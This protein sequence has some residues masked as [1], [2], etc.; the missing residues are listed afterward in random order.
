VTRS[1]FQPTRPGDGSPNA[2]LPRLS[3]RLDAIGHRLA[4][5]GAV[6]VVMLDTA[7]LEGIEWDYGPAAYERVVGQLQALLHDVIAPHLHAGDCQVVTQP[8]SNE[9]VTFLFR[10]RAD[11]AFYQ[12][13]LPAIQAAIGRRIGARGAKIVHPYRPSATPL[14]VGHALA[15]HDATVSDAVQ[16][17]RVL[18]RA[19]RDADLAARIEQQRRWRELLHIVFTEQVSMHYQPIAFLGDLE[20]FGYEALVRGPDG[21]EFHAPTDLFAA[22]AEIDVQSELDSLCRRRALAEAKSLPAETKLFL[23]CLPTAMRDPSFGGDTV[24]RTLEDCGLAPSDIVLEI[25]ERHAIENFAIFREARD[26]YGGLGFKI[27]LDDTGAGYASLRAVMELAPDFIKLDQAFVASID[28]DQPRQALVQSLA[29]A[30]R[31][32]GAQIIAEGIETEEE[33]ATLRGLGIPLGQGYLLGRPKLGF[34]HEEGG[35]PLVRS[36]V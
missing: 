18:D 15:L 32:L 16:I 13:E 35:D 5:I 10:H 3:D 28:V 31:K 22:A 20:L 4:A 33:L 2:G 7:A 12:R 29:V 17:R 34:G 23:N 24:R 21:S 9:I 25:S 1:P 36:P 11:V 19:R 26:Y 30:S 14:R 6:G 27:A 8:E